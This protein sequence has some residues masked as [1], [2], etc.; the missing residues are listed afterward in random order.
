MVTSVGTE[1]FGDD[2]EDTK[3]VSNDKWEVVEEPSRLVDAAPRQLS[4]PICGVSGQQKHIAVL[5]RLGL[6]R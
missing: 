4:C 1:A 5:H 2:I 6:G 3:P